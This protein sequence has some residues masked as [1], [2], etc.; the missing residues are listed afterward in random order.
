MQIITLDLLA[1]SRVQWTTS[2]HPQMVARGCQNPLGKPNSCLGSN[3]RGN[4]LPW[5]VNISR[6]NNASW[7]INAN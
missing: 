7:N 5:N 4:P 3:S 2:M 6:K 1:S